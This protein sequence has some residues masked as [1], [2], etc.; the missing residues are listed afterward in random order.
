[1]NSY[2][3]SSLASVLGPDMLDAVLQD[4]GVI[5][6]LS[7]GLQENVKQTFAYG[8]ATQIRILI[9]F[10]VVQLLSTSLMWQ[11]KQLKVL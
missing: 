3:K 2:L 10:T 1:M 7:S 6:S 9:G 8:Y 11:K 4:T 5:K